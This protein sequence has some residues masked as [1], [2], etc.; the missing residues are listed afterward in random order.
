MSPSQQPDKAGSGN[1]S[2]LLAGIAIGAGLAWLFDSDRGAG[3]RAKL[4]DKAASFLRSLAWDAQA[5]AQD[6]RNRA[7]GALAERRAGSEEESVGSDQLVARVRAA[8]G[9]QVD[10]VRPIEV[11]AENG[12]VVLRGS[13]DADDIDRV[14]ATVREVRGVSE[15]DNRLEASQTAPPG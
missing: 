1:S 7:Q 5:K 14:V 9:H 11:T 6:V 2:R 3:R 8:L 12:R 4:R 13:A 10:R 15:V